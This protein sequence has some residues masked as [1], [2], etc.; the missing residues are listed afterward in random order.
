MSPASKEDL[1]VADAIRSG[2]RDRRI[3]RYP[4]RTEAGRLSLTL[5]S[6]LDERQRP[7]TGRDSSSPMPPNEL[8]T[9]LTS[10]RRYSD[11]YQR[12]GVDDRAALDDAMRGVA[13][14]ALLSE[15]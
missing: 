11:L 7:T 9:P 1:T 4:V 8:R 10:I 6:M 5:N 14:E 3:A 13:S 15:R 12:G 2:D